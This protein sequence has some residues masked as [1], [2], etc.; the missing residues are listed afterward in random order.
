L[1]GIHI[2][3]VQRIFFNGTNRVILQWASGAFTFG[4]TIDGTMFP[5]TQDMALVIMQGDGSASTVIEA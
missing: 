4:L 2:Q 3:R 1:Q 5:I